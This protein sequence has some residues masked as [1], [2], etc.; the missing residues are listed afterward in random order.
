MSF[1]NKQKLIFSLCKSFN[2]VD[3]RNG[4]NMTV[5]SY[6]SKFCFLV[7]RFL[8][9]KFTFFCKETLKNHIGN[10]ITLFTKHFYDPT[11]F[12]K[13]PRTRKMWWIFN[14]ILAEGNSSQNFFI[15]KFLASWRIKESVILN[16][17]FR[18][19]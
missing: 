6:S 4:V 14:N 9:I 7:K 5:L 17:L 12:L 8:L 3:R 15:T 1:M 18:N 19:Q 13:M 10:E 16:S 11:V 2:F